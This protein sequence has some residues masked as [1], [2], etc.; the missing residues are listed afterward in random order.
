MQ[1][2]T[3]NTIMDGQLVQ[4]TC[5]LAQKLNSNKSKGQK[6]IQTVMKNKQKIPRQQ[7]LT[8]KGK[9][10]MKIFAYE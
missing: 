8:F 10:T 9:K 6:M 7:W 5:I 1:F 2:S 3:T 4:R